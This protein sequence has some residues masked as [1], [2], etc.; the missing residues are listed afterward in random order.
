MFSG[1][2]TNGP[3]NKTVD[4]IDDCSLLIR[5][6]LPPCSKP[7]VPTS[8]RHIS[9][10]LSEF[11]VPETSASIR[12]L[13]R[14]Q[15]YKVFYRRPKR[16]HPLTPAQFINTS[17]SSNTPSEVMDPNTLPFHLFALPTN[18]SQFV[19]NKQPK[20]FNPS[21]QTQSVAPKVNILFPSA[22][23]YQPMA[24]DPALSTIHWQQVPQSMASLGSVMTTSY[25]TA[26]RLQSTVLPTP[27]QPPTSNQTLRILS[28]ASLNQQALN[29]P[30][31][32]VPPL[33]DNRYAAATPGAGTFSGRPRILS[34]MHTYG[35]SN[36]VC[37][38]PPRHVTPP[39]AANPT[40]VTCLS[41]VSHVPTL[42]TT[43]ATTEQSLALVSLDRPA[44]ISPPNTPVS[45][46]SNQSPRGRPRK[47]PHPTHIPMDQLS[48]E[49]SVESSVPSAP[50]PKQP[51]SE[52]LSFGHR[53]MKGIQSPSSSSDIVSSSGMD[54]ECPVK[55][56]GN[57][58]LIPHIQVNTTDDIRPN[59]PGPDV[60]HNYS[61]TQCAFTASRLD[62]VQR[63]MNRRHSIIGVS[64][65][66]VPAQLNT[67]SNFQG[68]QYPA[69]HSAYTS[70]G[71]V[72]SATSSAPSA[73]YPQIVSSV[74]L[75]PQ[76]RVRIPPSI[77][78]ASIS[79]HTAPYLSL[80]VDMSFVPQIRNIVSLSPHKAVNVTPMSKLPIT[81]HVQPTSFYR[82]VLG[83]RIPMDQNTPN[84]IPFRSECPAR[85]GVTAPAVEEVY[86]NLDS[87]DDKPSQGEQPVIASTAS[88]LLGSPSPSIIIRYGEVHGV[89]ASGVQHQHARSD[90]EPNLD[91]QTDVEAPVQPVSNAPIIAYRTLSNS[92][93]VPAVPTP[94]LQENPASV[95][96]SP[97]HLVETEQPAVETLCMS[98][99]SPSPRHGWVFESD[100]QEATQCVYRIVREGDI[101]VTEQPLN[102]IVDDVDE[103]REQTSGMGLDTAC[104]DEPP[105]VPVH[106]STQQQLERADGSPDLSK[107]SHINHESSDQA[108]S[109][110]NTSSSTAV[111]STGSDEDDDLVFVGFDLAGKAA[112]KRLFCSGNCKPEYACTRCSGR[113]PVVETFKSSSSQPEKRS[114]IVLKHPGSTCDSPNT[115]IPYWP[116][117]CK[118]AKHE[119]AGSFVSDFVTAEPETT[120]MKSHS[121][122]T[123]PISFEYRQLTESNPL[124][125]VSVT[126][127]PLTSELACRKACPYS[128]PGQNS[129]SE[130]SQKTRRRRKSPLRP[131]STGSSDIVWEQVG[132]PV[133]RSIDAFPS[134]PVP[135]EDVVDLTVDSDSDHAGSVVSC[136]R[137]TSTPV[138]RAVQVPT[139]LLE[140]LTVTPGS[141]ET[142]LPVK[143]VQEQK[144]DISGTPNEQ[145]EPAKD[146]AED[147]D[148]RFRILVDRFTGEIFVDDK[149]LRELVP[150]IKPP[151]NRAR[152]QSINTVPPH[153]KPPLKARPIVERKRR[154]RNKLS[155]DKS[156]QNQTATR[157]RP[158]RVPVL[159]VSDRRV[160]VLART[161][162]LATPA[163]GYEPLP[164]VM[165][166]GP[167]PEGITCPSMTSPSLCAPS[168]VS[169]TQDAIT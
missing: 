1:S 24:M 41:L 106:K 104:A 9:S 63:H 165:L 70:P 86:V 5:V 6:R 94:Q 14:P 152:I 65:R 13:H 150:G 77:P 151:T 7:V 128:G 68:L 134:G 135:R 43:V 52:G 67:T 116:K 141:G 99:A 46:A 147:K 74:S 126:L 136:E 64:P 118:M 155:T 34:R 131:V 57:A 142:T 73:N 117:P 36:S 167:N 26:P 39:T 153:T 133:S 56:T 87:P 23:C 62:R 58:V 132:D 22:S 145:P 44:T 40:T 148:P 61:C 105:S 8:A 33:V 50:S 108:I 18:S 59:E 138:K 32:C 84:V 158:K 53:L 143:S 129:P 115:I 157:G 120:V 107:C 109:R 3:V 102:T 4:R 19:V 10:C 123:S 28:T 30:R 49:A 90:T 45:M 122:A 31:D 144:S 38:Q 27:C 78:P 82:E 85:E 169:H 17:V 156:M 96:V 98:S 60:L 88:G 37:S 35:G 121:R 75:S 127:V 112:N 97:A 15:Y 72:I 101:S 149:P 95:S 92:P 51:G 162:S 125:G 89:V 124:P 25:Y 111:D 16:L 11:T 146:P 140:R 2:N 91:Q 113:P 166:S 29:N 130:M 76:R 163:S 12:S 168:F 71:P 21:V 137:K 79:S 54:T 55:L 83:I 159:R 100:S 42:I 110:L 20:P 47:N 81:N 160:T 103:T 154:R 66:L 114:H 161:R 164:L 69:Q 119:V 80:S 48:C 93:P 139:L